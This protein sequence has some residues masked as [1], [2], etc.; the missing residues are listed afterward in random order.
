[1]TEQ[2]K[3]EAAHPMKTGRHDLYKEAMRLVGEREAKYDLV[4]LVNWLLAENASLQR[5]VD[6]WYP[7]VGV[8]DTWGVSVPFERCSCIVGD[9]HGPIVGLVDPNCPMHGVETE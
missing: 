6:L 8:G 1:M 5:K 4:N 2:E 3:I 9:I 7:K